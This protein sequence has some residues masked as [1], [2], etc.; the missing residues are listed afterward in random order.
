M[1][2]L[3]HKK[4]RGFT[5]IELLVVVG[6][7]SMLAAILL[8][9]LGR[10]REMS[11]RSVCISNLRQ[12]GTALIMYAGDWEERLPLSPNLLT[13]QLGNV[14]EIFHCPSAV[15]DT[16]VTYLIDVSD[17]SSSYAYGREGTTTDDPWEPYEMADDFDTPIM[18]DEYVTNHGGEGG[19]ILFLGGHAEWRPFPPPFVPPGTVIW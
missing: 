7:I 19:N 11:R 17:E 13:P 12:I 1:I 10:A 14:P 4:A 9:A 15:P 6:I 5:L 8:P 3:M 18:W 16:T 2:K